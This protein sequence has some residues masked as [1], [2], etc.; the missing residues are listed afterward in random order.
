MKKGYKF[1]PEEK[2]KRYSAEWKETL[3]LSLKGKPSPFK[4][5]SRWTDEQKKRIGE[6]QRG[7]PKSE[8]FKKNLSEYRKTQPG[9]F[10]GKKHTQEW[11]DAMS[12][13]RAGENH[14]NWKG[15]ITPEYS[16][17][18]S[19]GKYVEWRKSVF[20]RDDYTC[21]Q[22]GQRGGDLNADHILPWS[23]HP[24]HRFDVDNGRTLCVEC[25]K[26]TPTYGPKMQAILKER[27]V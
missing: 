1:S 9:F 12:M 11:R 10:K 27:T 2:A 6:A 22:C 19:S 21:V 4:G 7:K 5:K 23:T 8:E 17:L 24:E 18:R 14:H 3:S 15:G 25:H 16:R 26:Q 20:L 13:I